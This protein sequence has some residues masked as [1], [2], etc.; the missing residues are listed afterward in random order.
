MKSEKEIEDQ[1]RMLK[2]HNRLHGTSTNRMIAIKILEWVLRDDLVQ[3][4]SLNG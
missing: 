2:N 3:E 1:I 4:V